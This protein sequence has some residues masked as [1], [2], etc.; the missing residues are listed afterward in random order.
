MKHKHC[1]IH[2]K[3]RQ[4]G[5]CR[6][7]TADTS[8]KIPIAYSCRG[9]LEL[10]VDEPDKVSAEPP[11]PSRTP[12]GKRNWRLQPRIA[13]IVLIAL[14]LCGLLWV[15]S[16]SAQLKIRDGSGERWRAENRVA[17]IVPWEQ[18]E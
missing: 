11:R 14:A 2:T 10:I 4:V 18:A 12:R 8:G 7:C 3:L 16:G 5:K 15:S 17:I 13:A 1:P 6:H 9:Q